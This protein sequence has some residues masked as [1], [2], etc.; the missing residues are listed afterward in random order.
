MANYC[1]SFLLTEIMEAV[2]KTMCPF[3]AD[4]RFNEHCFHTVVVYSSWVFARLVDPFIDDYRCNESIK[5]LRSL[6]TH[7]YLITV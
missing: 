5:I 7:L 1:F 2:K 4:H 6:F 3:I